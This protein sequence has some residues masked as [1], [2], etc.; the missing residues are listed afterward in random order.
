MLNRRSLGAFTTRCCGAALSF[1]SLFAQNPPSALPDT[2]RVDGQ[3]L[4]ELEQPVR[5]AKVTFY[6]DAR[7]MC[8]TTVTDGTGWFV[9]KALSLRCES[10]LMVV[11]AKGFA[12]HESAVKLRWFDPN[13]TTRVRLRTAETLRGRVRSRDGAPIPGAN[14]VATDD[15]GWSQDPLASSVTDAEGNF[16]LRGV[17]LGNGVVLAHADGYTMNALPIQVPSPEPVSIELTA[18]DGHD[19]TITILG[20]ND[21][22]ASGLWLN[23]SVRTPHGWVALGTRQLG[24]SKHSIHAIPNDWALHAQIS[25]RDPHG[26]AGITLMSQ[27]TG[28]HDFTATVPG[29]GELSGVVVDADGKPIAGLGL[30]ARN[31]RQFASLAVTD[32]AGR[33][34][35]RRPAAGAE[36]IEVFVLTNGHVLRS[37]DPVGVGD[38]RVTWGIAAMPSL[39]PIRLVAD[40]AP[41]L[42]GKVVNADGTPAAALPARLTTTNDASDVWTT[43]T[44]S[45]GSFDF[46][47]WAIAGRDVTLLIGDQRGTVTV[48]PFNL[49]EGET[50]DTEVRMPAPKVHTIEVR[51][52]ADRPVPGATISLG[53]ARGTHYYTNRDGRCVVT[54]YGIP[55]P[56]VLD[57]NGKPLGA[58]VTTQGTSWRLRLTER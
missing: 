57:G 54:C 35:M 44:D 11:E 46:G 8:G 51:D 41:I 28:D 55:G 48:G 27:A 23:P 43:S 17:A 6:D 9:S 42:R 40:R 45:D 53:Q 39:G 26:E 30:K 31:H 21:E 20:V 24:A 14:V 3:I 38:P 50:K 29:P 36:Q 56:S 7:T 15:R 33:F 18:G 4:D 34:S 2:G 1:A 58:T 5:G 25:G 22:Q 52:A 37:N 16:S 19:K 32:A 10:I 47:R 13:H 49:K 12:R